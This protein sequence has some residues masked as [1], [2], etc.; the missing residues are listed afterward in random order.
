ME[1]RQAL[2]AGRN[3]GIVTRK[4]L[5]EVGISP[6]AIQRRIEKGVLLREYPGVYRVGHRAP[7]VEARYLAAVRASG[8]GAALS[9][10]AAGH[11]LVLLK[12]PPPEPEVTAPTER[13]VDGIRTHRSRRMDPRE[14]TLFHGVP[15]T[16]AARTL[17]DLAALL[18]NDELAHAVHQATVLHGTT[19]AHIEAVLER[20]PTSAGAGALRRVLHGDVDVTLS[21]LERRFLQLVHKRGHPRPVTNRLEGGRRVDCRWPAQ[22]LTV[23][24][25]GYRYHHS[26]HAWEADRRR[27]REARARGDEYR[28]YTYGD[29]F[30]QPAMMLA[31]LEKLLPRGRPRWQR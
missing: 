15:V 4:Q 11:L 14:V 27:E 9:G 5:L 2:I 20:R 18:S 23:E 25:D 17:V 10:R 1:E 3:H 26:R 29:V 13:R 8:Q 12:G 22:R 24:L 6:G 16:T 21:V 31:E 28:R 19:V 7:S 30:E